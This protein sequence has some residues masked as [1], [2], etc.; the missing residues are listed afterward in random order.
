MDITEISTEIQSHWFC[1]F[2]EVH[3]WLIISLVEYL[4]LTLL[5]YN[6]KGNILVLLEADNNQ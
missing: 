4:H 5:H 6:S 2:A 1:I 3:H